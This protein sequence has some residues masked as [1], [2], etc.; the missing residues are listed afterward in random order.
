M[1]VIRNSSNLNLNGYPAL[2]QNNVVTYI[3]GV[4]G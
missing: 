2:I 4:A 3:D 1:E